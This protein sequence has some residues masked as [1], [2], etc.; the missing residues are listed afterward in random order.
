MSDQDLLAERFEEHRAYLHTVAYR[1]L[2]STGEADDAVQE[3]WL[4]LSR[5]DSEVDNLR[6]WLTTVVGR[7]ALDLLRARKSRREEFEGDRPEPIVSELVE[8]NPAEEAELADSVGLAMLVVLE[9][10]SP[11]ERI[12]FVLHDMFSVPFS[13]IGE[14]TGRSADAARQLAS[15]GRRRVRGVTPP[16]APDVEEQRRVV[17]AFLAAAR[18]GDFES[19]LD[20]LDPEVVFRVHTVA[21]D[22]RTVPPS[23]GAEETA[24]T[25]LRFGK[26]FAPH[27]RPAMVNG[28][29]GIV[30]D[31]DGKRISAMQCT[32]RD[33]R[34]TEM[35]IFLEPLDRA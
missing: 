5:S 24:R 31:I 23:I 6:A 1:M 32:I 34:M 29:I 27:A 25:A 15:R 4:R 26:R 12:A 28:K 7:V 14:I 33:G 13:E 11:A 16:A 20:V 2:G 8:E 9:T 18:A 35:D 30:T 17:E 19:L 21:G 3:A 10:L 22:P